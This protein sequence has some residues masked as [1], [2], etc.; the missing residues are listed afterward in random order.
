VN[1]T[2]KRLRARK[3]VIGAMVLDYEGVVIVS[4][5]SPEDSKSYAK[6]IVPLFPESQKTISAISPKVGQTPYLDFAVS[7]Y[8]FTIAQD[9]LKL[10]RVLT[11]KHEI[12]AV[13]GTVAFFKNQIR[14]ITLIQA[15]NT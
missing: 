4:T 14:W 15:R 7:K 9:E 11:K 1:E 3:G 5:F 10:L 6:S 2:L 13:P 12:M 8:L